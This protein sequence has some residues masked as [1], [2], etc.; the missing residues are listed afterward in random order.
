M[1]RIAVISDIHG[2]ALA[3]EAILA[4]LKGRPV[5]GLVCL[6]DAIQGGPQPAEVV[7]RL[8][9]LA[10]PVVMGNADAWLLTGE[11]SGEE[12]ITS[13]RLAKMETVRRWSLEQLSPADRD[14]IAAFVSTVE[15]E[16]A[17][18]RRLLCFH[19]SPVSFDDIILPTTPEED[20]QAFL[21]P[22]LP[23]FQCGGHTHLQN[24]RPIGSA[25]YFNPGSVGLAYS[26]HQ[27][28][29]AFRAQ[30]WAEYAIFESGPAGVGLS[31]YRI[32]FDLAILRQ[33]YLRSGQPYAEEAV[34][35]WS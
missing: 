34:V 1:E 4:D 21:A 28:E 24:V 17:H 12:Q 7:A 25:F 29:G 32:G 11:S 30:P 27:D 14:F 9:D 18:G 22:Y 16:L 35:K 26:H 6:G 33:L 20:F 15:L 19:G 23:A 31:F 13:E 5:D 10:C 3:L 8:R 2:N